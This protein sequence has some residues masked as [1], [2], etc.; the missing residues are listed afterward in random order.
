MSRDGLS[1]DSVIRI[2][3]PQ[4]IVTRKTA[5]RPEFGDLVGFYLIQTRHAAADAGA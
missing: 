4:P 2:A 5:R 1:I 3:R